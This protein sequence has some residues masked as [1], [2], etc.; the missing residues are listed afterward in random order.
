M[1]SHVTCQLLS[2]QGNP[3]KELV[4]GYGYIFRVSNDP[5]ICSDHR[6]AAAAEA[7]EAGDAGRVHGRR[8]ADRG[9]GEELHHHRGGR[10]RAAS[11]YTRLDTD[12]KL[13]V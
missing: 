8:A 5:L 4:I 11:E 12:E 1:A 13:I 9:P 10:V 2:E 3:C 6:G 7:R